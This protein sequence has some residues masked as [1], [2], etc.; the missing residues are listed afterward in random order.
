MSD[1][2]IPWPPDVDRRPDGCD[3]I[4]GKCVCGNI[5]GPNTVARQLFERDR[6]IDRLNAIDAEQAAKYQH[7]PFPM[8]LLSPRARDEAAFYGVPRAVPWRLVE[9]HTTQAMTNHRQTLERLAERGGL[10]PDELVAVLEDRPW[11]PM[12]MSEAAQRLSALVKQEG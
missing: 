2:R 9:Q 12:T 4:I 5:H 8:L 10:R 11:K 6:L 1:L 3:V 7:A